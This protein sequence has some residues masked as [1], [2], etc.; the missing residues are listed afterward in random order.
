[1]AT[2]SLQKRESELANTQRQLEILSNGIFQSGELP[3]FANK[4][5][6]TNQFPLKPKS[7]EILQINV[8]YMCNQVCSHCHVDAGPDRKEIMTRET[9]QQC[10]NV[11]EKTGAHTLD[12]TGGA[13]EMNPHFRW[14]VEEASKIGVKDFIVR[15]NLTIIRANKKYYDLPEFFKKH[16]VHVV[17]SMP[18]WTRGKTDKQRGDGVFDKSIKALQELNAVGYG[19]PDSDL[20]L[21][22][23][24][25]P[26]GAFLPGDQMAMEKDFKKA[27]FDDFNIQFHNLF[28]ITNLPISRFLDYLIASENYEDYMYSLV[29]AFNPSAVA[30]VM[31]TN[32]ISVSWDGW[33]YDCDFNQMLDLKVASK[34]QHISEYNEEDLSKRNI[35]ISQ[36]CYGCTAGAGSSC[37]GTVA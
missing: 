26:S 25:N 5:K 11:I 24:Y 35:I 27:L 22:L 10:L 13:P 21:D 1:M 15:S 20:R 33:L 6:E 18:H 31:C 37:Q 34:S 28:A 30:S 7:I 12:L 16:N 23:V 17:S 9:M 2:K 36:H 3:T 8:G 14:F 29:E 19:M 4:I 32:T